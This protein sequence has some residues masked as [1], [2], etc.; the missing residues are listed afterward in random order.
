MKQTFLVQKIALSMALTLFVCPTF[1]VGMTNKPAETMDDGKDKF[2]G[3]WLELPH[4]HPD[5]N[6]IQNEKKKELS[7]K[8]IYK[9]VLKSITERIFSAAQRIWGNILP[10]NEEEV[11]TA[12]NH[13]LEEMLQNKAFKSAL[14]TGYLDLHAI[15]GE[16]EE[17]RIGPVFLAMA[18]ECCP[19][20]N[21]E[22]VFSF[23]E[24]V[25]LPVIVEEISSYTKKIYNK[26]ITKINLN[27]NYLTALP[28][29]LLNT[30]P[31]VVELVCDFNQL[32]FIPDF[33][34][35]R[36]V[37]CISLRFNKIHFYDGAFQLDTNFFPD[38]LTWLD[39]EGNLAL[40]T[41]GVIQN[42]GLPCMSLVKEVRGL[43][44]SAE[45]L[46]YFSC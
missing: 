11:Q 46:A 40:V 6:G 31:D 7:K 41:G 16:S 33:S 15:D 30:M 21:K 32:R 19:N 24:K 44:L 12:F 20:F 22:E 25:V 29:V 43:I 45:K 34:P 18:F 10:E 39:L 35:L 36:K 27:D 5:E 14:K 28:F 2:N 8:E 3:E 9:K 37:T 38:S 13:V 26:N 4:F 42:S 17:T 1:L 23:V